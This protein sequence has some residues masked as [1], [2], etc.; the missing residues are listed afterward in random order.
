MSNSYASERPAG[1]DSP[2]PPAT[3]WTGVV[4]FAGIMLIALGVFQVTEGAVALHHQEFHLVSP[5]GL[6][7]ETDYRVWGWGHLLLGLIALAG[8][9]GV[10]LGRLWGRIIGILIAFLGALVHFMFLAAAPL[11][12]TILICTEVLVIFALAVHGRDVRRTQG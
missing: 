1:A 11:W 3:D 12:C 2:A 4:A 10:L 8:G 6:L 9:A 7:I 5:D